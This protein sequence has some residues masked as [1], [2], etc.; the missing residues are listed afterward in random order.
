LHLPSRN[1]ARKLREL[2]QLRQTQDDGTRRLF[3]LFAT[4]AEIGKESVGLGMYLTTLR[5]VL[6]L[7]ALYSLCSLYAIVSNAR[8]GKFVGS[9][10][11]TLAL[12]GIV[13]SSQMCQKSYKARHQ[14]L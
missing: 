1:D 9:Y 5:Y 6:G 13:K 7:L 10:Q 4:P 14:W 12:N 3:S 8:A 11:L 2:Q